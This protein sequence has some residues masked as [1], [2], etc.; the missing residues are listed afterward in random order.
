MVTSV[1]RSSTQNNE[2]GTNVIGGAS[3]FKA[4]K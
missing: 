1:K 3:G 4:K 2:L